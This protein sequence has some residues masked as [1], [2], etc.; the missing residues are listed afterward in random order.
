MSQA[1]RSTENSPGGAALQ[2]R[3]GF[4]PLM[5]IGLGIVISQGSMVTMLQ[6]TGIGGTAFFAALAVA[7]FVSLCY[8]DTFA[9]LAL[10]LPQ[11]AGLGRYTEMALGPFAA[12]VVNFAGYVI[13]TFFAVAAELWLVDLVVRTLLPAL[14]PTLWV[15]FGVL[16]T[17]VVLNLVGLELFA[18]LQGVLT[19]LK[20][21][22]MFALGVLAFL[23][24][25]GS[26]AATTIA[27]PH[28]VDFAAVL[29]LVA[30]VIWGL[31]GAEYI[32][33]MIE[34]T[35][36]PSRNVPRA[37]WVTLAAATMLYLMW[38]SWA[39]AHVPGDRLAASDVPHLLL[40]EAL[41]GAGGRWLIGIA[42]LSASVG[43]VSSVLAAVPR[44]LYGMAREGHAFPIFARLHPRFRTPWAAILFLAGAIA[45]SL[46]V[47]RGNDRA[48]TVLILSAAS[49]WLL[50]YVVA[51][52]DV[53]VLRRRW[54]R[55]AR[56]YRSRWLPLPQVL[57]IAGMVY[58]LL[59]VSPDPSLTRSI[60]LHVGVV[61][62]LVACVAALWVKLHLRRSLF[63]PVDL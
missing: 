42:S 11:A 10:M 63:E 13:V 57:G 34:E 43:L 14:C 20:V 16:T 8:V 30:M 28:G 7:L 46:L 52:V 48:F 44:L 37:M 62:A 27:T 35:R 17:A 18:R 15:A 45:C 51:H 29:P 60:Y 38:V 56:P 21:S 39:P 12:I 36:Q 22:A 4:G 40:G 41:G 2:R 59:H 3:L 47:L 19:V 26:T 23:A 1:G 31:L 49:S 25:P 54:P 5:A 58:C 50:A 24:T 9:E 6:A 33:P 55:L 32:C 61:L 53:L